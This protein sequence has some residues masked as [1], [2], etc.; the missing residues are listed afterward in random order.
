MGITDILLA[1]LIL[2]LAVYILYRSLWKK[3]GSCRGCSGC[4]DKVKD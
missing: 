3:R 2:G 4:C 1:F